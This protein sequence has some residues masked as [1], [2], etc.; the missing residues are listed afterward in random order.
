[1]RGSLLAIL[2]LL[3]ALAHGQGLNKLAPWQ[4]SS[5][6][7][8]TNAAKQSNTISTVAVATAPWSLANATVT[9]PGAAPAAQ[10][11]GTWAEITSTTAAGLAQQLVVTASTNQIVASAWAVKPAGFTEQFAVVEAYCAS[12][13]SSTCTCT[14]SDAGSCTATKVGPACQ[15]KVSDLGTTPVRISAVNTC[16]GS[17]TGPYIVLY[18]GNLGTATG[19][20]KFTGAQ[21]EASVTAMSKLCVTTTT[22]KTCTD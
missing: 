21:L 5:K 8:R 22:S 20:T 9:T 6:Q 10:G 4:K 13:N 12:G 17:S 3:P 1:M 7:T 14:R 11:G 19:I 15:A 16:S 18:P 2:L